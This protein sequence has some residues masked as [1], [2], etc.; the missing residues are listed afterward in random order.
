M[1]RGQRV[2]V[3]VTTK[4]EQDVIKGV[5]T[6]CVRQTYQNIEI[7]VV[8]NNSKD[9]TQ[10]IAKRFTKKIFSFG[11]ERSAQRNFG[12]KVAK[13]EYFLF[14]DADM[15][16]TKGV[17]KECVDVIDKDGKVGAIA[18]PEIS[19][20]KTFWEKVKA[21][22]RS[23]YNEQQGDLMTDA[24]RFFRRSVFLSAGGYDE[25]ITGPEDWDLSDTIRK[26]G[27]KIGRISAAITHR[28]RVSSLFDLAKKK[29][30]YALRLHRYLEKQK[31]SVVS[32]KTIYFL[33]PVFYKNNKKI[34]LNPI[35]TLGMFIM[36]SVELFAGGLGYLLG[37]FKKL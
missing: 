27:Y 6:S 12:A 5:L 7:I 18:I 8:D 34:L 14:L 15:E 10:E 2:S 32:S 22:E 11:P 20:G 17:I 13:G 28:E 35:L 33:R 31:V 24:A 4:N 1:N 19:K 9:K 37:R 26:L 30:Y 3:I 16:L 23:F 25:T 36:L 21:F 29:F